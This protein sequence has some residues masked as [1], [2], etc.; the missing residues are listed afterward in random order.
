[1]VEFD[2]I[3]KLILEGNTP[4]QTKIIFLTAILAF[5]IIY[6]LDF[7]KTPVNIMILSIFV[8]YFL[9]IYLQRAY[10]NTSDFNRITKYKLQK[11]RELTKRYI[12]EKLDKIK[13]I[14][15][16]DRET[17]YARGLAKLDYLYMDVNFI[18]FMDNINYLYDQN[19][20][21]YISLL[22]CVGGILKLRWD[23]E[24]IFNQISEGSRTQIR[25]LYANFEETAR[26]KDL[27]LNHFQAMILTIPKS[28]ASYKHH[29]AL[30]TRLHLLL[31]RAIDIQRK[32]YQIA[33]K[34]FNLTTATKILPN[35]N[36]F[37][38]ENLELHSSFNV[39]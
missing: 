29:Q 37:T 35:E 11:L 26:L 15:Q 32:Y 39:Y 28:N 38:K 27:A 18:H 3:P 6:F 14:S 25:T 8:Y 22:K 24:Q 21:D 2:Y 9:N 5:A 1:M 7:E 36:V 20:E 19:K 13:F 23:S 34:N 31:L 4:F 10:N 12:T 16:V 33:S 30:I 17:V